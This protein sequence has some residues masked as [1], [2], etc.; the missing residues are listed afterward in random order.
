MYCPQWHDDEGSPYISV[1]AVVRVRVRPLGSGLN[2]HGL[3]P[4]ARPALRALLTAQKNLDCELSYLKDT[5][6]REFVRPKRTE[7]EYSP[8]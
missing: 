7:E 1:F 4:R 5:S 3:C 2:C 6:K 8:D